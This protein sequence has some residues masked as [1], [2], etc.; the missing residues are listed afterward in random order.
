MNAVRTGGQLSCTFCTSAA[1]SDRRLCLIPPHQFYRRA[2][3]FFLA[4]ARSRSAV[5]CGRREPCSQLCTAFGLTQRKWANIAWLAPAST[6]LRPS[7]GMLDVFGQ[8]GIHIIAD[9][10]AKGVTDFPH[11]LKSGDQAIALVR[12]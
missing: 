12:G 11:T 10:V 3:G 4:I 1:L 5:F 8:E 9:A 7:A 6:G 2:A